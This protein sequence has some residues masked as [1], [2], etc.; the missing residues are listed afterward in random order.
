[1]IFGGS[2]QHLWGMIRAMQMITTMSL[3]NIAF[4]STAN[5]FFNAAILFANMD[6]MSGEKLYEIIFNFKE[7]DPFN[8]KFETMDIG[9]KNLIMNS[10]SFFILIILVIV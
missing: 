6:V 2:M 5:A 8:E 4:P 3:I 7:T 1:M 9:S 10:G